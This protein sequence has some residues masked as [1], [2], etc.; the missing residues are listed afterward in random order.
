MVNHMTAHTDQTTIV[1]PEM[2]GNCRVRARIFIL[3]RVPP[4]TLDEDLLRARKCG[5][6]KLPRIAPYNHQPLI[7]YKE[8]FLSF[9]Q[10]EISYYLDDHAQ[11]STRAQRDKEDKELD[12][13]SLL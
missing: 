1:G 12:I 7:S 11:N 5:L 9:I 3:A 6:D 8:Y 13:A 4:D 10:V 2:A